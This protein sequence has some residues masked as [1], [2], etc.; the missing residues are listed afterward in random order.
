MFREYT[1]PE[2]GGTGY[3]YLNLSDVPD[4]KSVK[5][6]DVLFMEKMDNSIPI[7]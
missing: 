1:I 3:K 5:L 6:L 2:V 4:L 7:I